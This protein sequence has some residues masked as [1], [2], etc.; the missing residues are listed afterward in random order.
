MK[1]QPKAESDIKLR[2]DIDNAVREMA[3][4]IAD[5]LMHY[6]YAQ[7][8]TE[9]A[10]AEQVFTRWLSGE[11]RD[12]DRDEPV[13]PHDWIGEALSRRIECRDLIRK[14]HWDGPA[15][16]PPNGYIV[17]CQAG[18]DSWPFRIFESLEHLADTANSS[19]MN[20]LLGGDACIYELG[21]EYEAVP[22]RITFQLVQE[23][24]QHHGIT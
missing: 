3:A 10:V 22:G 4:S 17:T 9:R 8:E 15:E 2:I 23:E 7:D 11:V 16:E 14:M 18:D 13:L 12:N 5:M 24:E 19:L 6:S 20:D 21:R 1:K